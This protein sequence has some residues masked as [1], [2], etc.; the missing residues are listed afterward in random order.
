MKIEIYGV[1]EDLFK[2]PGCIAA[3]DFCRSYGLDYTFIPV[4]VRDSNQIGFSIVKAYS[5]S[6]IFT[7][8]IDVPESTN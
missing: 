7:E 6:F 2:C 1:P 3:V 8:N 5:S 4:I